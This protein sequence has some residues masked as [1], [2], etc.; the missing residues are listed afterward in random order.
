M[1]M[2]LPAEPPS[3]PKSAQPHA[4]APPPAPANALA[5]PPEGGS[6]N[7]VWNVTNVASAMAGGGTIFVR[8]PTKILPGRPAS[9][10]AA[11]ALP[12]SPP[13]PGHGQ[14]PPLP[15]LAS[16]M[17]PAP[18]GWTTSAPSAG[19]QMIVSAVTTRSPASPPSPPNAVAKPPHLQARPSLP[20]AL[21]FAPSA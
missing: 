1:A 9:P 2:A 7:D 18:P 6:P 15:A 20:L 10:A 19:F 5:L 3:P 14:D 8:A 16:A 17:P 4:P 12:P 11:V 21:A 13:S